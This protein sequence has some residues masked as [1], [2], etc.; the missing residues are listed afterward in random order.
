MDTSSPKPVWYAYPLEKLHVSLPGPSR[1]PKARAPRLTAS[2]PIASQEKQAHRKTPELP[3]DIIFSA[4][5]SCMDNN[6]SDAI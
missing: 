3:C 1:S 4:E 6:I 2:R 5:N